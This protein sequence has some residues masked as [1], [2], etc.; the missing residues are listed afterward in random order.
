MTWKAKRSFLGSLSLAI[1]LL[2]DTVGGQQSVEP[3]F[4]YKAPSTPLVFVFPNAPTFDNAELIVIRNLS[5]GTISGYRLGCVSIKAGR[6]IVTKEV[7]TYDIAYPIEEQEFPTR[8]AALLAKKCLSGG[9]L[10]I[11][12]VTFSDGSKWFMSKH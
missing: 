7:R 9:R 3:Q 4:W 1:L 5:G 12:S 2:G 8:I 6:P 10:A 11:T